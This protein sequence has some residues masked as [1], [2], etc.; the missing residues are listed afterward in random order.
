MYRSRASLIPVFPSALAALAQP[1]EEGRPAPPGSGPGRDPIMIGTAAPGGVAAL[2]SSVRNIASSSWRWF[3][4]QTHSQP[5]EVLPQRG[6]G[7]RPPPRRRLARVH[8]GDDGPFG[9]SPENGWFAGEKPQ[10]PGSVP[11]GGSDGLV[12]LLSD[13]RDSLHVT[14]NKPGIGCSAEHTHHRAADRFGPVRAR[15]EFGRSRKACQRSNYA[16]RGL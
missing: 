14:A 2:A 3:H 7:L 10:G 16:M 6:L 8:D 12:C 5:Q 15:G 11:F 1:Q 4:L 9:R 13:A